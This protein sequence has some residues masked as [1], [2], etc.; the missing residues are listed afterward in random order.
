MQALARGKGRGRDLDSEEACDA[1]IHDS[2]HYNPISGEPRNLAVSSHRC[3]IDPTSG[4]QITCLCFA[5]C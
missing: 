4:I 3:R 2:M 1:W 5:R